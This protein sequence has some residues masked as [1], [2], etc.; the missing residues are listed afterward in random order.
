[1][2]RDG[3]FDIILIVWAFISKIIPPGDMATG[4]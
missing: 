2:A 1:M 3:H 4:V